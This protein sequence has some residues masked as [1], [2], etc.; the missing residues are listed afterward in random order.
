MKLTVSQIDKVLF[1]GTADAVTVPSTSGVM[2]VLANH[3]PLIATL[4]SGNV[5][6]RVGEEKQ[7]F[8]ISSGLIEVGKD[9]ATVLV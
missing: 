8:P 1:E 3:M 7:V 9:G 5:V 6:V 2:T 4:K